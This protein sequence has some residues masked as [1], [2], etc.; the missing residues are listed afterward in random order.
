MNVPLFNSF[1]DH[2]FGSVAADS[3]VVSW[4]ESPLD[5]CGEDV[6]AGFESGLDGVV[7]AFFAA[8]P[9]CYLFALFLLHQEE[10]AF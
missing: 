5:L 1:E 3:E 2:S 10:P 4:P 9:Y 7:P 8:G 6:L